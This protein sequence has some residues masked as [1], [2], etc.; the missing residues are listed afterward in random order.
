VFVFLTGGTGY[1]GGRLATLLV[2]RGHTVRA[3][4]RR[5]SERKLP[6]GITDV[7]VGNPLDRTTFESWI[8]P[9][10]T[11]VQ[12]VGVAHPS[13]LKARQFYDVDL[14]S[15]RAS[16][17]AARARDVDH[18]VY[19]SVAQPAPIMKA[20]QLSRAIAEGHLAHSGL[21]S[22]VLRPWYV[23]G[24]GHRWPV[25]LLPAYAILERVPSTRATAL[26]LGLVTIEEMVEALALAIEAPPKVS[27]IFTVPDIRR[28]K[29]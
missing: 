3:L 24:P 21:S 10:C 29:L 9:G 8:E 20:Y 14:V 2:S 4:V 26:R 25:V 19:V 22:T 1:I 17:D 15:A 28:A 12:L 18:F 5:G 11:F 16:I 23:L 7:I 6:A 13:P 27:R